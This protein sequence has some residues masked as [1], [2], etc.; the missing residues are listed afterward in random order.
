MAAGVKEAYG[1]H[2]AQ[3]TSRVQ[4]FPPWQQT[5]PPPALQ[6]RHL[7]LHHKTS[8]P[9]WAR[10]A[11]LPD[12]SLPKVLEPEFQVPTATGICTP[13]FS[14]HPSLGLTRQNSSNHHGGWAPRFPK[15]LVVSHFLWLP[16]VSR[17][18]SGTHRPRFSPPSPHD[19][20]ETSHEKAMCRRSNSPS[21]WTVAVNY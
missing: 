21:G 14:S 1:A 4:P 19:S 2:M 10:L 5:I 16:A 3:A 15:H 6:R 20:G 18:I 17:W 11:N 8:W 13:F 12:I 7:L 9:G